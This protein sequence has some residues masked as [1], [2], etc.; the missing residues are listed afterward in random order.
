MLESS[1]LAELGRDLVDV[2]VLRGTFV[3]RSGQTSSYYIDKYLFTTRPDI[4]RRVAAALARLVPPEAQ[5]LA[6]PVLG[7]VPLV[8]AV[9]LETG[10]PMAIVR[11]DAPK[12]HGTARL[13]EG[14]LIE[15]DRVALVEDVVTTGGAA[16][17]AV[18]LLR[19]AG[20]EVLQALCVVDRE[21]GGS[22]AF[23]AA[24]VPFQAL[25]TRTQLDL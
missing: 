14:R 8:T 3:L 9:S 12:G 23:A 20:A 25:F 2:S 18:R 21:Q 7:A 22:E 17:E 5:R 16:L 11:T 13:I 1:E 19:E 24:G 10:V 6:G 4:L 15:G